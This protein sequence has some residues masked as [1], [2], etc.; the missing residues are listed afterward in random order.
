M[1]ISG[2]AAAGTHRQFA[3]QMRLGPGS[4]RGDLFVPDMEPVDLGL[5]AQRVR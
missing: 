4:E 2:S 5:P 3:G 1:Q